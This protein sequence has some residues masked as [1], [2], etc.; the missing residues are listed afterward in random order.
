MTLIELHQIPDFTELFVDPR[1]V[2]L[3][4]YLQVNRPRA[5]SAEP[6]GMIRDSGRLEA[7]LEI[8]E[9]MQEVKRLPEG[10]PNIPRP[11]PYQSAPAPQQSAPPLEQKA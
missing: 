3:M 8:L 11:A 4:M 1:F 10:R 7:Y 6:H 5:N 2:G 9:K